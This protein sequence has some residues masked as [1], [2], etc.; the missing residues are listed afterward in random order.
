MEIWKLPKFNCRFLAINK[1]LQVVIGMDMKKTKQNKTKQNLLSF[2]KVK[3]YQF[4]VET[5]P[6]EQI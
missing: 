6:K 5:C 4:K 3:L 1:M 2:V